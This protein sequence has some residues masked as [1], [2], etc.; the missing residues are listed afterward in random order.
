[1][2]LTVKSCQQRA[3]QMHMIDM[4]RERELCGGQVGAERLRGEPVASCVR[5]LEPARRMNVRI[6]HRVGVASKFDHLPLNVLKS[7]MAT[8]SHKTVKALKLRVL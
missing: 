2:T 3:A 1:M 5:H 4:T 7:A 8:D 6:E